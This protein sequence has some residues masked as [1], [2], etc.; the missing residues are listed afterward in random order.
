[1]T[2]A[3][4]AIGI[5]V[6]LLVPP[7]REA[8][9]D[10]VSGDTAAVRSDLRDLGAAGVAIVV[11]LAIV[12]TVVWYPAEI[13]DAAAGFV[14]GFAVAL[15]LLMAS[16]V[17]S[18]LLSYWIGRHVG[19]P[20]LYR[21]AGRERF[22]A[23]ELAVE[24]G[25][26]TL[27]LAIRLIPIIPFSL[28][29]TAAGAARVPIWRFVWTTAVG[30]LP[31]TAYFVYLGSRLDGFSFADPIV[32]IGALALI[33]GIVAVRYLAPGGRAIVEPAKGAG[34]AREAGAADPGTAGE[35]RGD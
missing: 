26:A 6:A 19:R 32:W 15:P 12:H 18:A 34:G 4:I 17:L 30:Y 24:R 11:W 23:L 20:I 28:S 22:E 27:L 16:W 13:L 21:F 25:G 31:L 2:L 5:A 8:L 9:F 7:L 33:V 14:Y 1:V 10:A 3:G 35:P 29:S